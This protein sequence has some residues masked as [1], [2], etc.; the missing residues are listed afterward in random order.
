M[1]ADGFV[2]K[3]NLPNNS[4]T[5]CICS[6]RYTADALNRLGIKTLGTVPSPFL[7]PEISTHPD[8]QLCHTGGK[9]VV[10]DSFQK[11]L[12]ASLAENGFAVITDASPE[13]KYPGDIIYNAALCADTAFG[14]TERL[15]EKLSAELTRR[16]TKT[17]RVNQ[18][19]AKCSVCVVEKRAIITDDPGIAAAAKRLGFDVLTAEKGDIFLSDSHY[20]FI[21]GCSGKISKD[22]IAFTGCLDSHRNC[23]QIRTFLKK[24]GCKPLELTN[25][26]LKDVGSILPVKEEK[27]CIHWV[28]TSEELNAR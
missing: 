19:Y 8:M 11:G 17:V 5:L 15:S 12:S 28:L 18:G 2:E 1:S 20:G 6:D 13:R 14:L 22:T 23:D 26:I 3:P 9:T 21:G 25:G 10:I 7:L 27:E 4:V 24:H 16:K